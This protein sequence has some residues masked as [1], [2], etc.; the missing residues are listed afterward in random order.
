MS[1]YNEAELHAIK[2]LDPQGYLSWHMP[3][4]DPDLVWYTWLE[5]QVA[6]PAGMPFLRCDCVA[7]L[8]SR[9]G[10][11]PPWACLIEAQAQPIP[12]MGVW[13]MIY[14]GLLHEDLRF[15]P[16]DRDRFPMMAAVLNLTDT[17]LATAI[18]WVPPV[19]LAAPQPGEQPS[20]QAPPPALG[21]QCRF[22]VRNVR[23]ERAEQ[24]LERIAA[25]EVALCILVWVPLMAGGDDPRVLQRWQE[26]ALLQT[27]PHLLADYVVLALVFA[28]LAGREPAWAAALKE[29]NVKDSVFLQ[30]IEDRGIAKGALVGKIQA[31]QEMLKQPVTPA[32]ELRARSEQELDSLLTQLRSQLRPNGQ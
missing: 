30:E 32:Q 11:Q 25:R 10:T 28:E 27:E 2:E 18:D 13:L 16:H 3:G 31:F 26:V 15:G 8:R 7:G 20:P 19:K 29:F 22:W 17:T 24:T 12:R 14:L 21:V 6:P 4:L 9:G 1:K 23:E 5:S